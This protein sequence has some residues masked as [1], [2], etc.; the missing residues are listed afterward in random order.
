[1]T[2][3][4]VML[5]IGRSTTFDENGKAILPVKMRLDTGRFAVCFIVTIGAAI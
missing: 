3:V 1:M 5:E 2:C 4:D